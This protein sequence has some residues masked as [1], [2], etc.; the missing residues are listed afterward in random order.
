MPIK[1]PYD[2]PARAVLETERVPLIYEKTAL[3]QDIRPLRVALLNLMPDKISTETQILR[4]IG[5]T[6]LQIEMTLL[7]TASYTGKNTPATH[8]DAFYKN[9][10]SIKEER[11]DAMI[12]TGAP[13]EHLIFEDVIYWKE[14]TSILEWSRKNVFST[15]FICWGAQA[16]LYHF[17]GIPKIDMPKKLFGLFRHKR[18]VYD[19]PLVTGFDDEMIVPVSRHTGVSATDIQN[20][21]QLRILLDH[22]ETGPCLVHD[23]ARHEIF[24][25]NHL[26]YE[27]ETL[28]NEYERDRQA[29]L[30]ID[31]PKEY[32][33]DDN[34]ALTPS[35][36]WRA[37]RNLLFGNWIN[38]VY[39]GTPFDLSELGQDIFSHQKLS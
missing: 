39:Q 7:R 32:F 37:H 6:P 34:P 16:A 28:K 35:V 9:W 24:M 1:I 21:E 31:L 8:M 10:E 30:P 18:L 20:H 36:S 25:F 19:D 12:V 33:P 38:M 22:S 2:L 11:F 14:L 4:A 29:G 3:K 27:A 17:Y 13:V 26:E 23:D 15:F 5:A